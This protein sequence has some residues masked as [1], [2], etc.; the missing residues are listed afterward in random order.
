MCTC[1]IIGRDATVDGS[2]LLGANNDWD[3]TPGQVVHVPRISHTSEEV[4][5]TIRGYE[6]RFPTAIPVASM[7][8]GTGSTLGQRASTKTR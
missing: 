6:I 7:P 4:F 5:R 3:G 2:V 8:L 1:T